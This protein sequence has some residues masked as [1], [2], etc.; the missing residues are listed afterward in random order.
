M[1][2]QLLENFEPFAPILV[3]QPNICDDRPHAVDVVSHHDAAERLDKDHTNRLFI[4]D[5]DDISEANSEHDVGRPVIGPHVSFDPGS[6]SY[7]LFYDPVVG[8]IEGCHRCQKERD[9]MSKAKVDEKHLSHLPI[10]LI[11]NISD[12]INLEFFYFIQALRQLKDDKHPEEG[13]N[14]LLG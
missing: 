11:I 10:L 7:S 13:D 1:T 12:E 9:N 3:L 6:I 14:R 5:C 8:R 4:I 2:A